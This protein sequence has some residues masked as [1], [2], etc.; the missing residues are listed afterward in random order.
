MHSRTHLTSVVAWVLV[1]VGMLVGAFWLR[2]DD[3]EFRANALRATAMAVEHGRTEYRDEKNRTTVDTF[4]VYEFTA[5]NGERVR[6][7]SPNTSQRPQQR[8][9]AQAEILYDP[10]APSSARLSDEAVNRAASLL[11]WLSPIGLVIAG[12]MA[13]IGVKMRSRAPAS[14]A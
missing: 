7:N 11:V 12:L 3:A 4:D 2:R 9:G 10:K 13:V 14:N 8:V 5:A 1:S 6:F